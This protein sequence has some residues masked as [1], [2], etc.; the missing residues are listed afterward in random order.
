MNFGRRAKELMTQQP[1]NPRKT[2]ILISPEPFQPFRNLRRL[3]IYT[4]IDP[5]HSSEGLLQWVKKNTRELLMTLLVEKQGAD[6]ETI[7]ISADMEIQQDT[8]DGND[9]DEEDTK[10]RWIM[11]WENNFDKYEWR[12][13]VRN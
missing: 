4:A 9:T 10:M 12:S 13:E 3:H 11:E 8:E 5:I 1:P 2:G 7:H 6:F